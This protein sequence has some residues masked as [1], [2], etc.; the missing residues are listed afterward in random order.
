[1]RKSKTVS[2][3]CI[4][5]AWAVAITAALM[6][7][8]ASC[9]KAGTQISSETHTSSTG[10]VTTIE[11]AEL[12]GNFDE[13]SAEEL[14]TSINEIRTREGLTPYVT[15]EDMMEWARIRAAEIV[16]NFGH[17][18]IDG[19]S[20]ISAYPGDSATKYESALA[21]G[22]ESPRD[23][24]EVFQL[25]DKQRSRMLNEE[26]TYIG[27]ACLHYGGSQFWT[28]VYLLP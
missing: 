13:E 25:S 18:R 12:F 17:T 3:R 4:K 19:S 11:P 5:G 8:L 6:L 9:S 22:Y 10:A 2:F 16:I 23:I 14:M 24:M 15:D 27:A 1:M 21:M 20:V 26:Y 7:L 28:V